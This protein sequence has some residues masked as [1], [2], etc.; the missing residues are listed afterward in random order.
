M[1]PVPLDTRKCRTLL[2]LFAGC[3]AISYWSRSALVFVRLATIKMPSTRGG[4]RKCLRPSTRTVWPRSAANVHSFGPLPSAAKRLIFAQRRHRK[5]SWAFSSEPCRART[6]RTQARSMPT[7][8]CSRVVGG[9]D[10]DRAAG[11]AACM[12]PGTRGARDC[13]SSG[14]PRRLLSQNRVVG[15]SCCSSARQ[16]GAS[17]GAGVSPASSKPGAAGARAEGYGSTSRRAPK[18]RFIA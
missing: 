6:R 5:R 3:S 14:V 15:S 13:L 17:A 10:T 11:L 18:G 8:S 4:A 1:R 12:T 9:D 16:G 2:I 7:T